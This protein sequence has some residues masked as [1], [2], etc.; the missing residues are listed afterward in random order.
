MQ[1]ASAMFRRMTGL[2]NTVRR[3]WC[4]EAASYPERKTL[5]PVLSQPLEAEYLAWRVPP[6]RKTIAGYPLRSG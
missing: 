6:G 3:C 4:P 1:P 2:L 5:Q